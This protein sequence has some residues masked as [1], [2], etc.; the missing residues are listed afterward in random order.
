MPS[1]LVSCPECKRTLRAPDDLIGKLVKCPTCGETFT[2]SPA[3]LVPA[4]APAADRPARLSKVGR[5]WH[6][7]DD[8]DDDRPRRRRRRSSRDED[9]EDED[10]R[11]RRRRRDLEPHRGSTVLVL[12][13]L[14][15]FFFPFV[16]GPIAWVMG[17]NDLREMRAGRMDP[18]GESM[19]GAG[20]ACGMIATLLCGLVV[21][22]LGF[23]MCAGFVAQTAGGRGF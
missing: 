23:C 16:L 17:N 12:G 9:D 10:D 2:A 11:P 3:A 21:L 6:D 5:D 15:F 22:T 7:D 14:S 18:E 13:I 19:T 4:P 20:R 8:D 1:E